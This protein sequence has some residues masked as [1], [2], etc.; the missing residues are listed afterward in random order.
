MKKG[1]TPLEVIRRRRMTHIRRGLLTGFSPL[2]NPNK[3][4]GTSL[5]GF[6]FVELLIALLIFSIIVVSLY[7]AFGVG[8]AAYRKGEC[9]ASLYQSI[10]LALDSMAL[11]LRNSYKF[12]QDNS[13][14]AAEEGKL[15]FYTLKKINPSAHKDVFQICRMEYQFEEARLL[16]KIFAGRLAFSDDV[17]INADILLDNLTQFSIEFPYQGGEEDEAVLWQDFW[18]QLDK[19]PLA[20]RISLEINAPL[21][22]QPIELTKI[23][24]IPLGELGEIEE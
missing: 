2:E 17:D 20:V 18:L 5:T 1:F 14:F 16:R 10:R 13:G 24:H 9:V 15:S 8:L 4:N 19:L 7:S 11:D 12:S 23:I 3:V 22:G 6:T 21:A